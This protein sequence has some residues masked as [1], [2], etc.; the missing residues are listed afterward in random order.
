MGLWLALA[1]PMVASAQVQLVTNEEPQRVFA[2]D[3]RRVGV[4]GG[5]RAREAREVPQ[6]APQPEKRM[7]EAPGRI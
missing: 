1:L 7:G 3:A 5:C 4:R 6:A 2:G